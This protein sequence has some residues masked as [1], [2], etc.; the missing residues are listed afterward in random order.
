ML[1]FVHNQAVQG[2]DQTREALEALSKQLGLANRAASRFRTSMP[3]KDEAIT[4]LSRET[5]ETA[6]GTKRYVGIFVAD[7]FTALRLRHGN[8]TS[9]QLLHEISHKY[10]SSLVPGGKVFRWSAQS[11]LAVWHSQKELA[12]VTADITDRCQMPC[13]CRAFVGTRTATFRITMRFAVL[14]AQSNTAELVRTLDDFSKG[15]D[16]K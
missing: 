9:E 3:N 11:I 6:A 10:I 1:A 7:I 14:N 2:R 5:E 8:E 4:E 15:A 12:E 16:T 13:D